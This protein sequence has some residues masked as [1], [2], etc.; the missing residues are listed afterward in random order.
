MRIRNRGNSCTV[1]LDDG[2]A[3]RIW[4]D[5]VERIKEWGHSA[6]LSVHRFDGG[7]C[8]HV[9]LDRLTGICV[10][11]INAAEHWPSLA[12]RDQEQVAVAA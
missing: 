2:S 7:F 5:D 10:R 6:R 9:L 1:E 11:I 12:V 4:P 3:W 8:T